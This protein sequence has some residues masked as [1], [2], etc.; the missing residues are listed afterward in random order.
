MIYEIELFELYNKIKNRFNIIVLSLH[1]HVIFSEILK[2]KNIWI[3]HLLTPKPN[4]LQE[5]ALSPTEVS[6]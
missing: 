5:L 1:F 4:I 3:L 2:K 6:K